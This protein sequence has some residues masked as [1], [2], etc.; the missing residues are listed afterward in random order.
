L[1]PYYKV[2]EVHFLEGL[3]KSLSIN[4]LR[5]HQQIWLFNFSRNSSP[6]LRRCLH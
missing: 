4:T 1:T 3:K 5:G 2:I 6:T